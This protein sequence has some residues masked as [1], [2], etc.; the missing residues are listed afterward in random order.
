MDESFRCIII[1]AGKATPAASLYAWQLAELPSP[2]LPISIPAGRPLNETQL[3][4]R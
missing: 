3:V 1:A 2:F 4:P